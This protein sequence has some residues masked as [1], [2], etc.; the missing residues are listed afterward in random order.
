M[1]IMYALQNETDDIMND[2]P[3]SG[4]FRTSDGTHVSYTVHGKGEFSAMMFSPKA[5]EALKSV[6]IKGVRFKDSSNKK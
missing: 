2:Y 6:E 1:D 4:F 3:R 5:R